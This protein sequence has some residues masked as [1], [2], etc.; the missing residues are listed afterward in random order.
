VKRLESLLNCLILP[1]IFG[2]PA[3]AGADVQ[4]LPDRNAFLSL[5]RELVET[6]TTY[7]SGDCTRAARQLESRLRAAGF[8]DSELTQYVPPDRPRDGGLVVTWNGRNPNVP[9]ILLLAHIDVVEAKREDWVR[10]PFKLIEEGG[11]FYGRGTSDDK[12]TDSTNASQPTRCTAAGTI[13][14][15]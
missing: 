7:S 9:A 15:S 13:C 2:V 1:V 4:T 12:H 3:M 11:Y 14:S 5:Y 8:T 6:N 10:D